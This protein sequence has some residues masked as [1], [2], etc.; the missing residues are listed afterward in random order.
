MF[1]LLIPLL[2]ISL[3]DSHTFEGKWA[4][5]YY[6]TISFNLITFSDSPTLPPFIENENVLQ[7]YLTPLGPGVKEACVN[8]S[9][10][11]LAL[12]N[13]SS[14]FLFNV[15]VSLA[16]WPGPRHNLLAWWSLG[17]QDAG[18]QR[19]VPQAGTDGGPR[20]VPRKLSVV[21]RNKDRGWENRSRETLHDARWTLWSH[22]RGKNYP[23][24]FEK[25]D[26]RW[27][28]VDILTTFMYN[29]RALW[30]RQPGSDC[31]RSADNL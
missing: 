25:A 19:Q 7:E 31:K 15:C 12:L 10:I 27:T 8:A 28:N 16:L 24:S 4:A 17:L 26:R 20:P 18:C 9:K 21:S 30:S 5:G 22:V 11:Y 29:F 6:F 2:C 14:C 3:T 1:N 23:R 13:V